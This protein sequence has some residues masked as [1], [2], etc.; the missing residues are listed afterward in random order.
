MFDYTKCPKFDIYQ[1]HIRM[2]CKESASLQISAVMAHNSETSSDQ[3]TKWLASQ[4]AFTCYRMYYYL[5]EGCVFGSW[6]CGYSLPLYRNRL[7]Q[8]SYNRVAARSTVKVATAQTQQHPSQPVTM[9]SYTTLHCI[10]SL[11]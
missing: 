10:R 9:S 2:Y 6:N 3:G 1:L 7:K 5:I 11:V 8:L 4:S